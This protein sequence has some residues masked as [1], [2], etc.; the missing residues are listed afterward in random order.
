MNSAELF[1]RI[2]VAVDSEGLS[3]NAFLQGKS[4]AGRLGSE[5]GLVHAVHVPTSLWP[6]PGEGATSELRGAAR[7]GEPPEHARD[8]RGTA[9]CP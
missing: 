4:L 9:T 7:D 1:Q 3:A 5:L 2:L 8:V 6:V